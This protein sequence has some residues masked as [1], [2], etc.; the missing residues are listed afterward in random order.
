MTSVGDAVAFGFVQSLAR[1]NGNITGVSNV[2]QDLSGKIVELLVEIAPRIR[3]LG[4]VHRLANPGSDA[5]VQETDQAVRLLGLELKTV[6]SGPSDQ[7][8]HALQ[9]LTRAGVDAVI[10]APDP[11]WIS[12]RTRIAEFALQAGWPTAFQRRESVEAGGLLSYGPSLADQMRKAAF[13][14]DRILKGVKPA[15]LPVQQP[16]RFELTINLKTAK[17]LGLTVSPML[18]ARADEVIE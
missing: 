12:H 16:T 3:R 5:R 1:P 10:F 2:A 18:L 11:L 13:Y 14:V 8:E 7:I 9:E 6:G 15:D 17:A 4:L